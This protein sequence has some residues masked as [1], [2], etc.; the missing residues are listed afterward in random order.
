[1]PP[2]SRASLS[3]RDPTT[4]SIAVR[5]PADLAAAVDLACEQNGITASE[6]LR[7]LVSRWAYGEGQLAGPDHGYTQARS[8]ASQLAHAALK[9]ALAALPDSHEGA[10][11][12]LQGYHGQ[13]AGARKRG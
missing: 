10:A 3:S 11:E 9:Q 13:L 4:R 6:L 2:S 8:M 12:M 5:L 1:M 7:D